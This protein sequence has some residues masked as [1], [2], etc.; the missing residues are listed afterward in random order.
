[1]AQVTYSLKIDAE[2]DADLVR[3]LDGQPNKSAAIR[4]A[5]RAHVRG[6]GITLGDVLQAVHVRLRRY[7]DRQCGLF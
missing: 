4:E 1:M 7:A 3:W 2:T 5:L 6:G